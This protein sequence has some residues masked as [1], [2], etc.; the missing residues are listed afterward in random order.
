M[1]RKII[2]ATGIVLATLLV[3]AQPA[4]AQEKPVQQTLFT[5]VNVFDGTSEKLAMGQDDQVEGNPIKDL[6]LLMNKD[7]IPVIIKDGKIY[8]DTL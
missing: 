2:V 5:N 6:L 8:K 4:V 3:M 1:T 7:K